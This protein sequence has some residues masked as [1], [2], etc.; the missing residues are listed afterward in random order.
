MLLV[1]LIVIWRTIL[2]VYRYKYENNT[3]DSIVSIIDVEF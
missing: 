1:K 2:Y 3:K